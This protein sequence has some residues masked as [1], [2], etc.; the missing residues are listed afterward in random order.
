G[1]D[2]VSNRP[3]VAAYRAPGAPNSTFG[4]ES[5][6]DELARMLD[7][8]PLRLREINAAKDGTKAAHGPTWANIGYQQTVEAAKAHAHLTTPL[9]PNQGR[10]I[11]SGF[12]FNIGGE[13]AATVHINEDGTASVVEGN[14]DIGGSRASMAMMAAGVLAIP[15]ERVRPIVG[16]TAQAGYCFLTGGSR[17]TFATGMAVTQ[18]AE[19]VVAEMKQRAAMIWDISHDAGASE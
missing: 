1:Y 3:K 13:S 14:P 15:Y 11:A 5:C 4:T 7:I 10:G 6:T 16:D 18:A 9:G 8:A 19:K 17:V 12:W 2:V